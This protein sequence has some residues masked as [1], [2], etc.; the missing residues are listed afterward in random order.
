MKKFLT[1]FVV[2]FSLLMVSCD[3]DVEKARIIS[4]QWKGNFKA[5]YYSDEYRDWF[6]ADYSDIV[7]YPSSYNSTHGDGQQV[8][9]YVDGPVK[10]I[11]FTF[12]WE[13]R[14]GRIYIYYDSDPSLDAVI[15]NYRLSDSEGVFS[16]I[17]SNTNGSGSKFKLF[18]IADYYNW[19]T[20]DSYGDYHEWWYAKD[21]NGIAWDSLTRSVN[22][23]P[24]APTV[25]GKKSSSIHPSHQF[26]IE[27]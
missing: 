1:L 22:E 26:A 13:V 17:I 16:G 20:Y 12:E 24:V 14:N 23:T 4:G 11:Y 21:N 27:R 6:D 18:K 9:F 25:D 19:S 15:S 5:C 7:F 10:K 3:E 8:D 2:A